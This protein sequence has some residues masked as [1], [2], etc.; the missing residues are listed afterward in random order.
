MNRKTLTAVAAF[1]I[2]GL[3][4][5]FALHQ[6]E[7]GEGAKERARPLAPIDPKAL[8]TIVITKGGATTTLVKEGAAY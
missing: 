8:D 4:A 5:F 1:A 7:K 2:L 6:P 3:A